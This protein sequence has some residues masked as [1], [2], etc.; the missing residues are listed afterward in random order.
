M[1][2]AE[3]AAG[4]RREGCR[5]RTGGSMEL[6]AQKRLLIPLAMLEQVQAMHPPWFLSLCP[7]AQEEAVSGAGLHLGP[8]LPQV[9]PAGAQLSPE[10]IAC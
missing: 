1:C 7:Q 8:G 4:W 10:L 6:L 2:G 5:G 9:G 3:G